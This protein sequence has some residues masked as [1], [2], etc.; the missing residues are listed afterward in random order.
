MGAA[1][2]RTSKAWCHRTLPKAFL[3]SKLTKLA[4]GRLRV[5]ARSSAISFS[6][7]A[8]RPAPYWCGPT[9]MSIC[10]FAA[11][12]TIPKANFTSASVHMIGRTVRCSGVFQTG[13]ARAPD[14]MSAAH[15]GMSP[16]AQ[17]VAQARRA[18][19]P[20]GFAYAHAMCEFLH[21]LGHGP[22]TALL[23]ASWFAT[24]LRRGSHFCFAGSACAAVMAA[25]RRADS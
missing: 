24:F 16:C 17:M 18:C 12:A 6:A 1:A 19:G 8:G 14:H 11:V 13:R 9:A 20:P 21:P 3:T 15:G 22:A 4:S 23:R 10:A 2:R 25:R 5:A 7:P